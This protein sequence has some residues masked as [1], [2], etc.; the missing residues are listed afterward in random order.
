[1]RKKVELSHKVDGGY[2]LYG[3]P[4]RLV[5]DI[6]TVVVVVLLWLL[7]LTGCRDVVLIVVDH[8]INHK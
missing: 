2:N 5:V 8:K 6:F 1:M 7:L 3:V 4:Q